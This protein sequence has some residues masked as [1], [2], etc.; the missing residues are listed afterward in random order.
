MSVYEED[1]QTQCEA[2]GCDYRHHYSWDGKQWHRCI[3]CGVEYELES[4]EREFLTD[5]QLIEEYG[6]LRYEK[7]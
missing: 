5:E 3:Y 4:D 6:E 2:Y 1:Y 7:I